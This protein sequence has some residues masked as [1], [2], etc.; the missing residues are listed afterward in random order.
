ARESSS[1]EEGHHHLQPRQLTGLL[2]QMCDIEAV[3]SGRELNES[4][5]QFLRATSEQRATGY[6]Q[7]S[8]YHQSLLSPSSSEGAIPG[9]AS[10]PVRN[11]MFGGG[12]SEDLRHRRQISNS[13]A[14]DSGQTDSYELDSF[15]TD[16]QESES[17]CSEA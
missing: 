2:R 7:S 4:D 9:F 5:R 1:A 12:L 16:D 6:D 14:R 10:R 15:V 8:V 11:G 13:P 3:E 17:H